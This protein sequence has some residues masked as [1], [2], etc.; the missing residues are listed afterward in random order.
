MTRMRVLLLPALMLLPLVSAGCNLIGV[1]AVVGV[2]DPVIKADY[3]LAGKSVAILVWADRSVQRDWPG[4]SQD[5]G[6]QLQ[7][8]LVALRDD[9]KQKQLKGTTFPHAPNK[10]LEFMNKHPEY[11]S[12]PV[13]DYAPRFRTDVLLYVEIER[14]STQSPASRQLSL[15]QAL[16]TLR[17]YEIDGAKATMFKEEGSIAVQFPE[18]APPEGVQMENQTPMYLGTVRNL[19]TEL[20]LR[21]FNHPEPK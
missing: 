9:D 11:A 5:L 17:I 15:G 20:T 16:A 4:L 14:F 7:T 12:V 8:K 3:E 13:D 6:N 1:A 10:L 21:F 18:H 2:P 19:S